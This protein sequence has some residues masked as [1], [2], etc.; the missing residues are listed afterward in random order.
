VH[1][2]VLARG[3][4]IEAVGTSGEI[5]ARAGDG[6]RIVDL[7]GAPMLPGFIDAHGHF[8]GAGLDA[9]M[10]DVSSPPVGRI[11]TLTEL[12]DALRARAADTPAGEWVLGFGYD[13][14]LLAERRH[15]TR[16]DLDA[17]STEHPIWI[18]HVSYHLAAANGA[19]LGIAGIGRD[20]PNPEGGVIRRDPGNGEPTGVL[21]ENAQLLVERHVPQPSALERIAILRRAIERY[22]AAGVTTAQNGL[23]EPEHVAPLWWLS[24]VG[25]LPLRL[26]LWPKREL[27][28]EILEGRF[29]AERYRSDRFR[30]GAVKLIADGSIQGY[31][32]YLTEPYH[33]PF[34]G[35]A[36][37]RGYPTIPREELVELVSRLHAA[38]LQVAV[39]G[40]GDAAIDD[41]LHALDEAQRRHPR[42][43]PRLVVVHAQTARDDQLETMKALG[44]TPS[45]FVAH[46]YYWGDRHRDVF[47]GPERAARISPARSAAERGLRFS[48]HSDTPVVPMDP[49][50]SV[51]AAV[52][53]ETSGGRTLG[54]EQ[55]I[56]VER[57]LRA[58]TIDA[59][60]QMFLD[61]D[62]G[63]IE[64]GKLA[65]FVILDGDPRRDPAAIR[66]LAVLE[67]IVGGRSV[68]RRR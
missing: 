36:A 51:W 13:D 49:L 37:Y 12:L 20:T 68:Y 6:A 43:D 64:P 19:A 8:P 45:F 62:R 48:I 31:T 7:E 22:A 60:W 23:A 26:V 40:N 11:R 3:G 33:Q 57:A 65:D 67:T 56:D 34:Q 44:A 25:F 4:R 50:L 47:L 39:H 52:N 29:D 2:A 53:R 1:E 17:V 24:R 55:R 42:D 10:V 18:H 16:I 35:D 28:L 38:G 54:E 63:S 5:R 59:A 14:T 46:A 66:S 58:V 32:A 15:P 27:G 21:E 9:W 41:I 30:I 61:A